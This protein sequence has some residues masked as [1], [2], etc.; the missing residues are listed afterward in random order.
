MLLISIF[1]IIPGII[2]LKMSKKTRKNIWQYFKY[3]RKYSPYSTTGKNRMGDSYLLAPHP[4]TN[5]SL[6]PAYLNEKG[7]HVHTIEGFRKTQKDDSILQLVRDNPNAFKIVCIGGSSTH[8]AEMELFQDTW[9]AKL[10]EKFS[11][12]NNVIVFNFGVGAWGTLHSLIRCVNWLPIVKPNL[13][14]FYQAKNDLTPLAN[15]A[16]NEKQ[17]YPDYQNVIGQFSESFVS[18][19]PKWLSYIPFFFLLFYFREYNILQKHYGLLSVYRPKPWMNPKGFER[20]TGE[21]RDGIFFRLKTIFNICASLDCSVLYIPEIV[22][23][24]EYKNILDSLYQDIFKITE[25]FDHVNWFNIK[26]FYPDSDRYFLDK[27]HF[28]KDGCDLFAELLSR[29]I[30]QNYDLYSNSKQGM[31]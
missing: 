5:W 6:N 3:S 21:Y 29:H 23:S 19:F 26:E 16:E 20:L 31:K 25:E 7:D 22:R 24:S 12:E 27:M 14:V 17:L 15:A 1:V 13:L 11:P 10:N 9:P 4:F 30:Q 28:S 2:M 18:Y 8:C